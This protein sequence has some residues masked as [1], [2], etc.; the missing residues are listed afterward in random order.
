MAHQFTIYY[1]DHTIPVIY[2]AASQTEYRMMYNARMS[3]ADPRVTLHQPDERPPQLVNAVDDLRQMFLTLDVTAGSYDA[4]SNAVIELR[5]ALGGAHSTAVRAKT[6][7]DADEVYIGIKLDGQT[8]ETVVPIL[9]GFVDDSQSYYVP[10]GVLNNRARSVV[11]GVTVEAYSKLSSFTL[12]NHL[13]NPAFIT[14]GGTSGLAA[15]WG[16]TAGTPALDTTYYLVGGKSQKFTSASASQTLYSPSFTT[17]GTEYFG[18]YLWVYL[19]SGQFTVRLRNTTDSTDV[20]T[21][22]SIT[23]SNISALASKSL[24]KNGV[25][26][27]RLDFADG[28]SVVTA[29]TLRIEVVAAGAGVIYMDCAYLIKEVTAALAAIP[30]G[31]AS[32]YRVTNQHYPDTTNP[33]RINYIDVWGIPG[34]AHAALRLEDE[35]AVANATRRIYGAVTGWGT[36][37]Q[38]II[39]VFENFDLFL[40]SGAGSYTDTQG[41]GA[42]YTQNS[43]GRYSSGGAGDDATIYRAIDPTVWK[44]KE[45]R[46]FA[47]INS[48]TSDP[49]V[50]AWTRNFGAGYPVPITNAGS[51]EVMDLGL[52]KMPRVL[53]LDGITLNEF[54]GIKIN[55]MAAGATFDIDALYFMPANTGFLIA[56][57]PSAE[58]FFIDGVHEAAYSENAS[59]EAFG[60][61][62]EIPSGDRVTRIRMLW[63][64]D[65]TAAYDVTETTDV[66]LK[67]TPRSQHLFG[68]T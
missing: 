57:N 25:T 59:V 24:T 48:S 45:F 14:E 63:F 21:S 66:T 37:V 28:E 56:D 5:R 8:N 13:I 22:Y 46:L 16:T 47:L 35:Y 58:T 44:N 43:Y 53:A 26:W 52:V 55:D 18:S 40:N 9:Y 67:I 12:K 32:Y 10:S 39:F 42:S 68:T 3:I 6:I 4:N 11:I 54:I 1:Q 51:W 7:G 15:D 17:S 36:E 65:T 33:E 34:D 62:Y 27:Y 38:D 49:T 2:D 60:D 64:D 20:G 29:K 30:S 23:T 31:W 61:L 41:T 50:Q 19:A